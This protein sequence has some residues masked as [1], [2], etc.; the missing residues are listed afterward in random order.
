PNIA[1]MLATYAQSLNSFRAASQVAAFSNAVEI[2]SPL[3]STG[4]SAASAGIASKSM[5]QSARDGR[6]GIDG[7]S[8]TGGLNLLA[9]KR[10]DPR[11]TRSLQCRD[12]ISD[13]FTVEPVK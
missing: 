6:V 2:A 9:T 4:H 11:P 5:A 7:T 10:H 3:R 13:L 12:A 1:S 8:F